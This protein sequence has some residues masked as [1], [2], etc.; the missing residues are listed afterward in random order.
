VKVR[1]AMII[2]E[3]DRDAYFAESAHSVHVK[4]PTQFG[5]SAHP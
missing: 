3:Q 5:V 1:I 2:E 4:A